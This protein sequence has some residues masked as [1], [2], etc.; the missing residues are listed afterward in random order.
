[1][2]GQIYPNREYFSFCTINHPQY[3]MGVNLPFAL[4]EENYLKRIK[5]LFIPETLMENNKVFIHRKLFRS[6]RIQRDD[7]LMGLTIKMDLSPIVSK[8]IYK[9]TRGKALETDREMKLIG[10]LTKG[11]VSS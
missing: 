9:F 7:I 10:N 1:M 3:S 4:R 11:G 2:R 5:S 8:P 6:K